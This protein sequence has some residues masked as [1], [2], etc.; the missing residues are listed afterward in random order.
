M[1]GTVY[2]VLEQLF[3]K[4][5]T[6]FFPAKYAPESATEFLVK[7]EIHP[8]VEVPPRFRGRIKYSYDDCTGC[9]LC[10][11]VCPANV[12]ELYPVIEKEKKTKRIVLYMSRCT[13]CEECVNVCPTA[14][15][16]MEPFFTMADGNKYSDNLII[17][18][19]ERRK[20][21]IT[22]EPEEKQE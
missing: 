16:E 20:N 18:I 5:V 12:I 7:G 8:P 10:L 11:R 19:E 2:Q 13:F 1:F 22:E 21:E 15:L 17:G 14:A 3:G 6:N 9:G 4:K